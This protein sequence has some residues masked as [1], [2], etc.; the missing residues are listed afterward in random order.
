MHV[1]FPICVRRSPYGGR[2]PNFPYAHEYIMHTVSDWYIPVCIAGSIESPYAFRYSCPINHNTRTRILKLP[3]R[4]RGLPLCPY[5]YTDWYN[6]NPRTHI[7]IGKIPVC[8]RGFISVPVCIRGWVMKR[9]PYAY[10]NDPRMHTGFIKSPYA[11][12]DPHDLCTHMG[13][14]V[15]SITIRV[16]GVL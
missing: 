11:F 4:I 5:T 16:R 8:V 12:G 7:G 6:S 13:I 10:G 14:C 3:I 1:G 15:R 2:I 9:S